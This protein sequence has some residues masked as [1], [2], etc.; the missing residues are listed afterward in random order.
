MSWPP[1]PGDVQMR[2]FHRGQ[3]QPLPSSLCSKRTWLL[4]LCFLRQGLKS[5][6]VKDEGSLGMAE[7]VRV[8]AALAED[9]NLILSSSWLLT[10]AS[11]SS[12]RRSGALFWPL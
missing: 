5:F 9:L 8:P 2:Q 3:P 6:K 11:S 4:C 10:R 7:Q 12:S 1:R